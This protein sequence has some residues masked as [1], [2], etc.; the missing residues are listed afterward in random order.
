MNLLIDGYNLMHAV[1]QPGSASGPDGL[2]KVRTRFLN[3]LADR[4]GP[5][6]AQGA[7][8]VFDA[9]R[10]PADRPTRSTHKGLTVIFA[11]DSDDADTYIEQELIVHANP[12]ALTVVSSD[13]RIRKMARRRRA[14][15]ITSDA[16]WIELSRPKPPSTVAAPKSAPEPPVQ[17]PRSESEF[18]ERA[19]RDVDDLIDDRVPG[20]TPRFGR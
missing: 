16:F 10:G 17:I 20:I 11:R 14:R 5:E 12:K 18:W 4:L 13:H 3:D 9:A 8:V 2:R 6:A 19:F 7:T 15:D 1:V